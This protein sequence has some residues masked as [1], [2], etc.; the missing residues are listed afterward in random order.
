MLADNPIL[1]R[2][3][4]RFLRRWPVWMALI[5]LVWASLTWVTRRAF[6][7]AT[8]GMGFWQIA[9]LD[10]LNMLVRADLVIAF[11]MVCRS[12]GETKW[13]RLREDLAVRFLTPA[14][15]VAGKVAVPLAVLMALN[16]LGWWISY[17]A[18][19]RDPTFHTVATVPF[20]PP[21]PVPPADAADTESFFHEFGFEDAEEGVPVS[22]PYRAARP[23]PPP[24]GRQVVVSSALPVAVLGL[25][26]DFLYSALVVLIAMR[27]YLFRRDALHATFAGL[28]RV[29]LVGI[30][31]AA[32]G[33]AWTGA[34][35]LL[36]DRVLFRF[37]MNPSL[38]LLTGN[39]VW[40]GIVV[41]L[42]IWLIRRFW[43]ALVAET[44]AWLSDGESA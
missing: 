24:N 18:L 14:E 33:W 13:H 17:G 4:I 28:G 12:A 41:P 25:L 22:Q 27:A 23:A 36:P 7:A 35:M 8:F 9:I 19:V 2:E 26:E 5:V 32:A 31:I 39:A 11:F 42:E 10:T 29:A 6:P 34:S 43:R 37:A 1:R 3:W 44:G 16:V 15:I 38:D 20:L 30:P 21:K 40:F